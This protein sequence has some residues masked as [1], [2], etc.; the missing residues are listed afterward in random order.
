M[1][2]TVESNVG[3]EGSSGSFSLRRDSVDV[4]VKEGVS[5]KVSR[6]VAASVVRRLCSE[7]D[8]VGLGDFREKKENIFGRGYGKSGFGIFGKG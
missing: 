8:V 6:K 4:E 3:F 7:W 2:V 5:E 1:R